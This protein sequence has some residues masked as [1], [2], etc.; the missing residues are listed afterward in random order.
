MAN[1]LARVRNAYDY[2]LIDSPPLAAVSDA[3]IL[4]KLSDECILVV[5]WNKTP[6]HVVRAAADRLRDAG[7]KVV[8]TVLN[9]VDVRQ[10]PQESGELYAYYSSTKSYYQT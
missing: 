2:V 4:S 8:G 10:L 5:R 3:L 1:L 6:K 9:R 7:A